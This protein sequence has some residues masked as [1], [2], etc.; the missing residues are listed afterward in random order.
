MTDAEAEAWRAVLICFAHPVEALAV[1]R[2][3]FGDDAPPDV[4]ALFEAW[5]AEGGRT[6]H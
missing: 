1:L 4:V 3:H 6:R 2:K 5:A